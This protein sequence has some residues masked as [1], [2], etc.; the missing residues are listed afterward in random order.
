MHPASDFEFHD[1]LSAVADQLI[2]VVDL[3]CGV[4]VHAV[5]GRRHA[6][7]P[8]QLPSRPVQFPSPPVHSAVASPSAGSSPPPVSSPTDLLAWY[9]QMGLRQFYLADLDAL[10]GGPRQWAVLFQWLDRL[11]PH[12]HLWIDAGWKGRER[13]EQWESLGR[14]LAREPE[15][16]QVRWILASETAGD[17]DAIDRLVDRLPAESMV[18]G[19]DFRS[20][21]FV[22]DGEMEHWTDRADA[23][24]IRRGV[25]L[26]VAAVGTRNQQNASGPTTVPLCESLVGQFPDWDWVSGGGI[27]G[28]DDVDRLLDAGCRS[29]L[30]ASLLLPD[31]L[32]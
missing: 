26:D 11:L 32:A 21:R 25:V 20:G 13:P 5:G 12:E 30:V 4:A 22:G 31:Q 29:C 28:I 19:L 8:V 2:G 3:R 17:V 7:R 9:R 15:S 14:M 10:T 27:R 1:R 16:D 23:A 6:Y 18:L 24:G